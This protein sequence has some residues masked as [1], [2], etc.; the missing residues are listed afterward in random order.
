MVKISVLFVNGQRGFVDAD[1]LDLLIK[2]RKI[3]SFRRS[4]GWVRVL[5]DVIRGD[6]GDYN[7]TD[8]RNI[9][10]AR[11][12][13]NLH[14]IFRENESSKHMPSHRKFLNRLFS[15]RNR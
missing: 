6:G 8:R 12:N 7:G 15:V 4:S 5:F 1:E 14:L 9:L 10:T 13:A 3:I 2:A 11:Q